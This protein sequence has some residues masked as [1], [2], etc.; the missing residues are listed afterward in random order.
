MKLR[1]VSYE[2]G[3]LV[4]RCFRCELD[5]NEGDLVG[6]GD[7]EGMFHAD[8][9]KP[10]GNKPVTA[11]VEDFDGFIDWL[12]SKGIGLAV[13]D[14]DGESYYLDTESAK[15]RGRDYV[16]ELE[17]AGR[18]SGTVGGPGTTK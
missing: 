4:E 7:E 10:N 5:C 8:C 16:A 15:T 17:N 1:I 6:T 2:P 11:T 14:Y 13:N 18:P 3:D 9:S 12:S